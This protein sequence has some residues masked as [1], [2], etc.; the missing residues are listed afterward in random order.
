MISIVGAAGLQTQ[1]TRDS[2]PSSRQH[3]DYSNCSS[4]RSGCECGGA[5]PADSGSSFVN[6]R[7]NVSH[8]VH[9]LSFGDVKV[10]ALTNS[11][12]NQ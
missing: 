1:R 7:I 4:Y 5:Q 6:A 2:W 11:A 12:M 10:A 3:E 9:H 8:L